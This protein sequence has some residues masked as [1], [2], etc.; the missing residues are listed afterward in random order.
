MD[1]RSVSL[2]DF[3]FFFSP[4]PNLTSHKHYNMSQKHLITQEQNTSYSEW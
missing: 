4:S 2:F 1:V 3:G